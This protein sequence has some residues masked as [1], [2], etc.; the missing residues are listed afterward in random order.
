MAYRFKEVDFKVETGALFGQ[1]L[2]QLL[3]EQTM[4]GVQNYLMEQGKELQGLKRI[5]KEREN[6]SRGDFYIMEN[7]EALKGK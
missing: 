6:K 1:K 2:V 4:I 7:L 3:L 5:F